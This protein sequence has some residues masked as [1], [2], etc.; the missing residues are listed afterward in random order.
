MF[1]QNSLATPSIF[2]DFSPFRPLST[3]PPRLGYV[4]L[5]FLTNTHTFDALFDLNYDNF[6][7]NKTKICLGMGQRLAYQSLRFNGITVVSG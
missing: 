7:A 1:T 4:T 5:G 3:P 6:W 2:E